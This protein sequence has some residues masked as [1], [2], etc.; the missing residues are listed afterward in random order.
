MQLLVRY[1]Q[2]QP[3]RLLLVFFVETKE[4]TK[5]EGLLKLVRTAAILASKDKSRE[6]NIEKKAKRIAG[7]PDVE[8]FLKWLNEQLKSKFKFQMPRFYELGQFEPVMYTAARD[9]IL[10]LLLFATPPQRLQ[11]LLGMTISNAEKDADGM[12]SCVIPEHKTT[13]RYGSAIMF[14]P[15]HFTEEFDNFLLLRQ[16]LLKE[17]NNRTKDSSLL[18]EDALFVGHNRRPERYLTQRFEKLAH[19][20]LSKH[21]T[22]RDCRSIYITYASQHTKSMKEMY[23]LSRFMYHSF[24]TQQLVYRADTSQKR[25]NLAERLGNRIATLHQSSSNDLLQLPVFQQHTAGSSDDALTVDG[26]AD[27]GEAETAS[28]LQDDLNANLASDDLH[29]QLFYE[30]EEKCRSASL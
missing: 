28:R 19:D 15:K 9:F 21:V 20:K 5:L 22:I 3:L 18:K 1:N 29:L 8:A 7:L 27:I 23:E 16:E 24:I 26:N 30:Y 2:L 13:H 6:R 11:L 10:V 17:Q 12:Y 4:F 14:V 25:R